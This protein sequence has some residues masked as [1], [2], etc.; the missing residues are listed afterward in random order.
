[1]KVVV[2]GATGMVGQG[3][4]RE[5]LLD[6]G[7]EEVV[8]IG[9]RASGVT[10]R[11]FREVLTDDLFDLSPLAAELAGVDA[12]FFCLGVSSTGMNEDDYREVTYDITMAA[13]AAVAAQNPKAVFVYVSGAGADADSRTMWARVRGETE[14]ALFATSL[15]AY[16]LRP[17]FIQS[18]HGARSR[19]LLYRVAYPVFALLFPLLRRV[20]PK[21]VSSTEQIGLAM[22]GI[23]RHGAPERVLYSDAFNAITP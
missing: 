4:V 15:D 14:N 10:D 11:K 6:E 1:M 12:C 19:T 21:Y 23:A 13:A 7:V 3:V 17:G 5:C 16:V 2:F 8:S 9:R 18:R 22:L 20:A